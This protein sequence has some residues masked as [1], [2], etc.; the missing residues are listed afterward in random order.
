[1]GAAVV[2]DGGQSLLGP[3]LTVGVHQSL[4][5]QPGGGGGLDVGDGHLSGVHRIGQVLQAGGGGQVLRGHQLGVQDD[6]SL[7]GGDG[8]G[9]V[10]H[11]LQGV[12]L[13]VQ[14]QEHIV[15]LL[16]ALEVE[17]AHG[18]QVGLQVGALGQQLAPQLGGAVGLH[19]ILALIAARVQGVLHGGD[20]LLV[21]VGVDDDLVISGA[22]AAA[23]AGQEGQGQ[24]QGGAQGEI[25]TDVHWT[26]SFL[27]ANSWMGRRSFTG[28][29]AL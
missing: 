13:K 24:G 16:G 17:G 3:V 5:Q 11:L 28:W 4:D 15:L 20:G 18:H 29:A 2:I 19:D 14:G 6:G 22:G 7:L 23:A 21:G 9:V 12:H 27:L 10:G 8:G 26:A 25:L 1:M